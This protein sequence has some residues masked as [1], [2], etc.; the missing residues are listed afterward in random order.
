MLLSQLSATFNYADYA[1]I[2]LVAL[3]LVIGIAKGLSRSLYG[4]FYSLLI[5][6]FALCLTGISTEP[7]V[8]TELG[9]SLN[10]ALENSSATWGDALNLEIYYCDLDGSGTMTP[11]VTSPQTNAPVALAS[12]ATNSVVGALLNFV[13]SKA[14]PVSITTPQDGISL[15]SVIVPSLTKLIFY[16][17]LFIL[18]CIALQ[19]IF[20]IFDKLWDG[21]TDN[22]LRLK[23]ID[24]TLGILPWAIYGIIFIFVGLSVCKLL[25]PY[26]WMQ[27]AK[28]MIENSMIM[29]WLS[30]NNPLDLIGGTF[31]LI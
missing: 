31:F 29:S 6:V 11:C 17:A 14:I 25:Y 3:F 7:I 23:P 24:H 2:G 30:Q 27:P 1:F 26:P 21:V 20:R 13:V 4:V 28:D 9:V 18:F 12:V 10:T 19:L 22:G 16:T 8:K 15:A 5:C